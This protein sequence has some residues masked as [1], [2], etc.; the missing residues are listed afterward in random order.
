MTMEPITCFFV[1]AFVFILFPFKK[2]RE[3]GSE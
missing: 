3:N 1:A 2:I